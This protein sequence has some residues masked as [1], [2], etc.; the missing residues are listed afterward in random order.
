M[1]TDKLNIVQK[2]L[3]SI[4]Y[5]TKTYSEIYTN[6]SIYHID[7][8]NIFLLKPNDEPIEVYTNYYKNITL[9][10]DKSYFKKSIENCIHGNKHQHKKIKKY[11]YKLNHNSKICF[12][13]E[14]SID[15]ENNNIITH[16]VYF[17]CVESVDIKELFIKQEIIEFLSLLN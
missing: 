13:I 15:L 8:K 14:N 2:S 16:D 9:I 17:E 3:N 1:N 7:S 10:V 4:L 6:E 5:K 12:I 11:I